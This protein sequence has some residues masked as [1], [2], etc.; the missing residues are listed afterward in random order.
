VFWKP[1]RLGTPPANANAPGVI[2]D[3]GPCQ[4]AVSLRV[5]PEQVLPVRAEVLR[6][7]QKQAVLPGFRKGKAPAELVEQHYA[8]PIRDE[9]RHRATKDSLSRMIKEHALR[10]VGPFEVRKAEFTD[11]GG[12]T[13]EAQVEVEPAFP[14]ASYRGVPLTRRSSEVTPEELQQGLTSLQESMAK[15]APAGEGQ[16]KARKVP[17]LDDELAKDLGFASLE[18]LREHVEAKLREQKRTAQSQALEAGLCDA[19]L[20][21]HTFDV[22]PGLVQRQ[23]ERLT[24]DFKAR[25]LLSGMPEAQVEGEAA[26]FTEQLRHS[27]QRHVKLGFIFERIA[28]QETI[29]I[30]E[31]EVVERL[32]QLARQWKKDPAQVRQLLDEQHLWP[33]VLSAIRQEK[34]VKRLLEAAV[35][36][37]GG[38][39]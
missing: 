3:A 28:E 12:L 39:T 26:K 18:Q 38:T 15:L 11:Q 21:R 5:A 8:Q 29:E 24:R 16:E 36:D 32:W 23:T 9:I 37:N 31:P 13:I 27:A 34:T 30:G 19:L 1:A 33:S 20:A 7:F 2:T 14:L 4:K 25:L 10:P 35:I 6:E 22:P 17:P